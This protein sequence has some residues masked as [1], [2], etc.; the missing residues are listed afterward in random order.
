[1]QS[2]SMHSAAALMLVVLAI[3]FLAPIRRRRDVALTSSSSLW[4]ATRRTTIADDTRAARL[5]RGEIALTLP[6]DR[7]QVLA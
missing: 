5:A 3:G 6:Q 1:M 2:Q 7:R 4:E